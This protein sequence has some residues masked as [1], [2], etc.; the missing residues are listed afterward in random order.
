[1]QEVYSNSLSTDDNSTARE[2]SL[3]VNKSPVVF[4][5][6]RALDSL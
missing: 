6:I 1:M 2:R 5:I 4:I 3:S